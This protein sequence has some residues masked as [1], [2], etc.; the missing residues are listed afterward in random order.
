MWSR[1]T[2]DSNDGAAQD[3]VIELAVAAV[4][5]PDSSVTIAAA[6]SWH[7]AHAAA[8][9]ALAEGDVS[10][11]GLSRC[12]ARGPSGTEGGWG[13]APSPPEE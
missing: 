2:C 7:E 11:I 6:A 5:A 8:V 4:I 10:L 12:N 13:P 1:Y 9:A 3:G